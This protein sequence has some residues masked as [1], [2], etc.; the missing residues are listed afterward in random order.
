M[1]SRMEVLSINSARGFHLFF[2]SGSKHNE[3]IQTTSQTHR[4]AYLELL[5]KYFTQ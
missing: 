4:N 5:F 2:L 3:P 1:L